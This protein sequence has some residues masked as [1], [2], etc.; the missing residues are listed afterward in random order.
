MV[1]TAR[2]YLGRGDLDRGKELIDE[3]WEISGAGGEG[4]HNIHTVVPA[5]IGRASYHYALEEYDETIAVGEAGLAI[6]D[7]SGYVIWS[8]HRLLPTVAQAYLYKGDLD[9]AAKLGRRLRKDAERIG[10]KLGLAWADAC[11]ALVVWLGGDP[12]RGAAL[13]RE[14]A[15]ALEAI[16]VIPDAARIR[17]QLAGRLAE[18]GDE[19]GAV[20]ELRRVHETFVRLGAE[21]ELERT[22]GMFREIGARPPTRSGVKG[23]AGLTAREVEISR[24]VAERKSN[25][26]IARALDLSPRT[27]GTHLSNIYKKLD[28]GT[29]GELADYVRDRGLG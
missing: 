7:R 3:A 28:I 2:I 4:P 6:A 19:E 25:K 1:W 5:H 16:P 22:R 12:E 18:I 8:I 11:D 26:A 9:G 21:K 15:E 10:H 13:L 20:S 29:R 27:V 23:A 14:A 17:R 24:L